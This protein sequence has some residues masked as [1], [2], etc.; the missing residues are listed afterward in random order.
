MLVGGNLIRQTSCL[1]LNNKASCRLWWRV[2]VFVHSAVRICYTFVLSTKPLMFNSPPPPKE[3]GGHSK[4]WLQNVVFYCRIP[5]NYTP[6]TNMD[7]Q[8]DGL[9]KK[10]LLNMAIFGINSLNFSGVS[11]SRHTRL[12]PHPQAPMAPKVWNRQVESKIRSPWLLLYSQE[13]WRLSQNNQGKIP[14]KQQPN[15][16]KTHQRCCCLSNKCCW[17]SRQNN[18]KPQTIWGLYH[19]HEFKAYIIFMLL[20]TPGIPLHLTQTFRRCA[21]VFIL[22]FTYVTRVKWDLCRC[23]WAC[24]KCDYPRDPITLSD[25]NHF[26]SKVFGFHYHS[27]KVIGSLGLQ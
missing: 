10:L 5:Q 22:D 16:K 8:N 13:D 24:C 17:V 23:Y 21:H 14:G 12:T 2:Y 7:T 27:Q 6:K 11:F 18:W 19:F 4:H 26:L 15:T 9:E 1:Y 20:T 3:R 25:D